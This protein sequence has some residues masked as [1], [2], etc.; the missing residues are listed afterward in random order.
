MG[1]KY[2]VLKQ[3]LAL[4]IRKTSPFYCLHAYASGIVNVLKKLEDE[5][6]F[7]LID[8]SL[9]VLLGAFFDSTYTNKMK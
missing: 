9:T 2:K 6:S 5:T 4:F 3:K 1:M 7:H 8:S